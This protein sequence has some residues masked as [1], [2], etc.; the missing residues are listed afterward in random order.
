MKKQKLTTLKLNKK[1]ISKFEV[2][3]LTGGDDTRWAIAG[4]YFCCIRYK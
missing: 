1:S 4:T 3:T 2:K